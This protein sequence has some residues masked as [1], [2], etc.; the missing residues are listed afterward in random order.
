M[1]SD[2]KNEIDLPYI[3]DNG[4]PWGK[5]PYPLSMLVPLFAALVMSHF[6]AALEYVNVRYYA[7]LLVDC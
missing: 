3:A 2:I 7:R 6:L 1:P 5:G 4:I